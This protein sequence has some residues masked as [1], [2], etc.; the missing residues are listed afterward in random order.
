[1]AAHSKTFSHLIVV[2]R[3]LHHDRF[4]DVRE[5]A[6]K[7]RLGFSDERTGKADGLLII[8]CNLFIYGQGC[9]K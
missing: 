8:L 4:S 1:M 7:P 6:L 9:V 3:A 2:G 5:I